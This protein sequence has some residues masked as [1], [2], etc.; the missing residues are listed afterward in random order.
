MRRAMRGKRPRTRRRRERAPS[1][2]KCCAR[3]TGGKRN[4]ALD[5]KEPCEFDWPTPEGMKTEETFCLRRVR[6]NGTATLASGKKVK[7]G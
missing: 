5:R 1:A 2:E 3:K 4:P 6:T 7:V